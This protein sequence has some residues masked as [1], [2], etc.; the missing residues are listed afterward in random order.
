MDYVHKAKVWVETKRADRAWKGNL[1]A[2]KKLKHHGIFLQLG[3]TKTYL[4]R[5]QFVLN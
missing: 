5:E 4:V 1:V 3:I 2:A